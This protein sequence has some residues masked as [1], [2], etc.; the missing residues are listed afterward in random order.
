MENNSERSHSEVTHERGGQSAVE[1]GVVGVGGGVLDPSQKPEAPEGLEGTGH[2]LWHVRAKPNRWVWMPHGKQ[3]ITP[4][5]PPGKRGRPRNSAEYKRTQ[6]RLEARAE[7]RVSADDAGALETVAYDTLTDEQQV[8][9]KWRLEGL[10]PIDAAR[11]AIP[12]ME[13]DRATSVA[14]MF[15]KTC[16]GAIA[17]LARAD[18]MSQQQY[19]VWEEQKVREM[20]EESTNSSRLAALQWLRI[21]REE[22]QAKNMDGL[23][24]EIQRKAG[25]LDGLY[26]LC[27]EGT[28]AVMLEGA[29]DA[30]LKTVA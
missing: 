21:R 20:A 28:K 7:R 5:Q 16:R 13:V 25:Q 2:W 6:R 1:A 30:E 11:K 9:V 15:E 18:G 12:G 24:A 10:P 14:K 17:E 22:R 4:T 26:A 27:L 23:I 19:D 3:A 29:T 8:Y